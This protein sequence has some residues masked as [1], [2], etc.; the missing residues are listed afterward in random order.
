M[1]RLE[2]LLSDI[3]NMV[4][5]EY[6]K[7]LTEDTQYKRGLEHI[8]LRCNQD[9]TPLGSWTSMVEAFLGVFRWLKDDDDKDMLNKLYC[10]IPDMAKK[11]NL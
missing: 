3:V 7:V 6:D 5:E 4:E 2:N 9:D 11:Y 1:E 8:L 10:K